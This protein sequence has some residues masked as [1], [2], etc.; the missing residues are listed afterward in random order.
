MSLA[1]KEETELYTVY[2]AN[3]GKEKI[4]TTV[5]AAKVRTGLTGE[6]SMQAKSTKHSRTS[7]GKTNSESATDKD[8]HVQQSSTH[9]QSMQNVLKETHEPGKRQSNV[10]LQSIDIAEATSAATPLQPSLTLYPL[11]TPKANCELLYSLMSTDEKCEVVQDLAKM[12]EDDELIAVTTSLMYTYLVAKDAN[13]VKYVPMDFVKYLLHALHV[14]CDGGYENVLYYLSR[15]VCNQKED[16][17]MGIMNSTV[18]EV[19]TKGKANDGGTP[20]SKMSPVAER[21]FGGEVFKV[22]AENTDTDD[23]IRKDVGEIKKK[24]NGAVIKCSVLSYTHTH[25][26]THTH[27]YI[28]IYIIR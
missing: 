10:E 15:A 22:S 24:R 5:K 21:R 16:V 13:L 23:I 20:F 4:S 14:L 18:N 3:T 11:Q 12:L 6:G 19:I 2:C 7:K 17:Q 26:H 8:I 28:Y 1:V 9:N 27:I 25:T